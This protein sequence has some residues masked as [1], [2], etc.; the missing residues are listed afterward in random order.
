MAKCTVKWFNSQKGYG[1]I[2]PQSGGKDVFVHIAIQ[3]MKNVWSELNCRETEFLGQ[4]QTA[5][6]GARLA[7]NRRGSA[8]RFCL[9]SAMP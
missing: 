9:P 1:F 7:P 2:Q 4:R 3:H 8:S 6:K 5:R